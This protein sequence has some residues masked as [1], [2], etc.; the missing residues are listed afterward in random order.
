MKQRKPVR[1]DEKSRREHAYDGHID[2]SDKRV[3]SGEKERL[4]V[5][6]VSKLRI[7]LSRFVGIHAASGLEGRLRP[8]RMP[9]APD[10]PALRAGKPT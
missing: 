2:V 9:G 1:Y 6:V 10:G 7:A 8:P 4:R 3:Q 5:A